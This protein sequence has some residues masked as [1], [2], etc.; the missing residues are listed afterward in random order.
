M[1]S[2]FLIGHLIYEW[3][4]ARF[5]VWMDTKKTC[6]NEFELLMCTKYVNHSRFNNVHNW[7]GLYD[8]SIFKKKFIFK[9]SYNTYI[10][11]VL[12]HQPCRLGH[13]RLCFPFKKVT[14]SPH[15]MFET[16]LAKPNERRVEVIHYI[17]AVQL[18]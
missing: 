3:Y 14:M 1:W 17:K 11:D 12:K 5:E 8:H 16:W 6:N 4:V 10:G 18:L 13:A 15:W 2:L 7:E 9:E